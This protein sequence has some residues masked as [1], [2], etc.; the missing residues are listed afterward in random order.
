MNGAIYSIFSLAL[1]ELLGMIILPSGR[2]IIPDCVV[3]GIYC[4]DFC[5]SFWISLPIIPPIIVPMIT[6]LES[7]AFIGAAQ[8]SNPATTKTDIIIFF[9]EVLVSLI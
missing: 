4:C 3:C 9:F 7:A 2:Y 6:S 1:V 8:S 5:L